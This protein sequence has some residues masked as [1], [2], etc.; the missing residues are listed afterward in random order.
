MLLQHLD[1]NMIFFS[2]IDVQSGG[3]VKAPEAFT[4]EMHIVGHW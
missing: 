3:F 2:N 1:I 4:C